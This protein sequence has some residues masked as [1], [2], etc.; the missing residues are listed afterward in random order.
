MIN[1]TNITIIIIYSVVVFV[2]VITLVSMRAVSVR[3]LNR[4]LYLFSRLMKKVVKSKS[5]L[6]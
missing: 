1:L 5:I 6:F 2:L 3:L 4:V